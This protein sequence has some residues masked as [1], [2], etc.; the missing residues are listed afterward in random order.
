MWNDL[1]VGGLVDE[2]HV[3]VGPA[4]PGAGTP[5]FGGPSPVALRLP[6]S[7]VLDGSQIV[8]TRYAAVPV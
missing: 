8:L 5:V 6:E 2:L 4:L 7:R 3:M 1:R